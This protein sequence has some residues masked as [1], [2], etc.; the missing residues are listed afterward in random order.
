MFSLD[1]EY[2]ADSVEFCPDEEFSNILV[3]GTYQLSESAAKSALENA[4]EAQE[5]SSKENKRLGRCLV[6]E[7]DQEKTSL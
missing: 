6:Y 4:Q 3:C 2:S 7:F 5:V 1:T